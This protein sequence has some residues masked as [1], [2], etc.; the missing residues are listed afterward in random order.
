MAPE[1]GRVSDGSM[2]P[3]QR[4][5]SIIVLVVSVVVMAAGCLI[6][7]WVT[8]SPVNWGLLVGGI[9]LVTA[10]LAMFFWV[11]LSQ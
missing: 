10:L 3:Q 5:L 11:R 4:R 2:S 7:N 9:A 1:S 8:G 6:V